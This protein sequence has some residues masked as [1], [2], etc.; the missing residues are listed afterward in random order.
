VLTR[1]KMATSSNFVTA[2]AFSAIIFALAVTA[3]L[4]PSG[5]V[6]K[7]I[8][9]LRIEHGIET[10]SSAGFEDE[11][12]SIFDF[13]RFRIDP[14][15]IEPREEIIRSKQPSNKKIVIIE[16]PEFPPVRSPQEFVAKIEDTTA[17][18]LEELTNFVEHERKIRYE[19]ILTGDVESCALIGNERAEMDCRGE[20]Y[21][22]KAIGEQNIKLCDKIENENL[23]RYCQ[24][25]TFLIPQEDAPKN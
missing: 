7:E 3:A 22:Q 9:D 10:E 17:E 16:Q 15:R 8:R 24:I 20:I 25:Y 14:V 18:I 5:G 13:L 1:N 23:K 21:F 11:G 2:L 19:A 6:E 4:L 12:K